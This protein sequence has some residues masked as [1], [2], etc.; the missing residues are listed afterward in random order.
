[1]TEYETLEYQDSK[2]IINS[3][4]LGFFIGLAVIVPGISGSAIAIIFKLYD[5]LL[6]AIGN[7]LKKFKLCFIFLIPIAIGA[8]LG[9]GLGFFAIQ[10]LLKVFPFAITVFFGG[11]MIGAFPAITDEIKEEKVTL[12]KSLL[13]LLGLG[14]PLIISIVSIFIQGGN[15][16]FDDI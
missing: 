10:K 14:I 4:I 7:I 15:Q 12:T 9:F 11:L 6:Y 8:V 2:E 3:S 5:K 13:F 1:M 16:T